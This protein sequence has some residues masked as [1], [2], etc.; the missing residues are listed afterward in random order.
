M[1]KQF[2]RIDPFNL[3]PIYVEK[4]KRA[5]GGLNA[6][7]SSGYYVSTDQSAAVIIA[8]PFKAAQDLPF[9]RA[10]ME[11]TRGFV[12][13]A[14]AGVQEPPIRTWPFRRSATPAATRSPRPTRR[15]SARTWR[16]TA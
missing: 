14:L 6:D 2:V 7:F 4:L 8:K 12:A 15:S 5:G 3:L 9:S 13:Q 10:V 11:E 16:S 1:A